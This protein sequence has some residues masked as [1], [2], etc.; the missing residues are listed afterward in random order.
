MHGETMKLY[1]LLSSW[2]WLYQ[3]LLIVEHSTTSSN[4]AA[5]MCCVDWRVAYL[6]DLLNEPDVQG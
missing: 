6:K 1:T 5:S 2:N 3:K 4:M